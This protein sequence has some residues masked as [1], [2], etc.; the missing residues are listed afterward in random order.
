MSSVVDDFA[1]GKLVL[2]LGAPRFS[3]LVVKYDQQVTTFEIRL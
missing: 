2:K 3:V 1:G